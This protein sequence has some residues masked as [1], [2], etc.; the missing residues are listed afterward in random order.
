M[1]SL[2]TASW[3][4]SGTVELWAIDFNIGSFDNC[5]AQEDLRYTFSTTPPEDDAN[6]D[7]AQHSS[8]MVFDG[9]DVLNSPVEIGVVCMG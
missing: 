3:N 8:S 5:T 1:V 4:I 9:D 6:Y 7:D 2:S